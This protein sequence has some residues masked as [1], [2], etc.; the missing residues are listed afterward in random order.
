[1]AGDRAIIFRAEDAADGE[2]AV[3]PVVSKGSDGTTTHILTAPTP[4]AAAALA[5]EYADRG[6]TRVQLCGATGYP[7]LAEV[8]AAVRGRARVDTVLFGFESL[9]GIARYK[10][11]AIAGE[12]QRDLFLYVLPGADPAEDRFVRTAGPNTST[13]VAVPE[14]GAGAA[15]VAESAEFADGLGLIEL[16]GDWDGDAV[17]A[18]IRAVDERVPVGIAVSSRP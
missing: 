1:M 5:A 18:V 4:A 9:L 16:Y 13:F 10:E 7:W 6:V 14:P 17:A 8:E 2:A 12:A 3:P 15:V 11:R